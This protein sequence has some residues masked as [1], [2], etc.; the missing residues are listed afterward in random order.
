MKIRQWL[1]YNEDASQFALQPGELRILNNLQ[2]R[3]PG[4][5]IARSGLRKL[6]G[7]YNNELIAA[8][9]RRATTVGSQSDFLWMVRTLVEKNLSVEEIDA[10]VYPFM[11]EWAVKRVQDDKERIIDTLPYDSANDFCVAEDRHGRLFIFYGH[12]IHPRLY[13]PDNIANSAIPLGLDP[14][15]SKP[16]VLPS[17]DGF[18]LE[19][20]NII[21]GGATY[22]SPPE[23]TVTGGDPDREAKVKSIVE[24]GAV[25]GV[26]IIDGGSGYKTPPEI[27]VGASSMGVGF[28][29]RGI[30]TGAA[31]QATGFATGDVGTVVPVELADDET[32]GTRSGTKNQKILY[33]DQSGSIAEAEA[34]YNESTRRF[35]AEI[36]A[37]QTVGSNGGGATALCQFSPL[38]LGFGLNTLSESSSI[39]TIDNNFQK[40]NRVERGRGNATTSTGFRDFLYGDYWQGA[41]Y[42]VPRSSENATYGGL[43]ASGDRFVLG[44]SGNLNGRQA[45]VYWPD[46][47]KISVWFNTGVASGNLSQWVREDVPVTVETSVENETTIKYIDVPLKPRAGAKKVDT[48]AG[49]SASTNYTEQ[50]SL[51][52]ARPP[53]VRIFLNECPDSW[54]VGDSECLPTAVKESRGQR[55][56]W[57]SNSSGV[58]RPLVDISRNEDGELDATSVTITDPG[59]GWSQNTT[60]AIRLYQA[61]AYSQHVDYNTAVSEQFVKSAHAATGNYVE[62]Q[63]KA[64]A[65]DNATPHGPPHTLLEPVAIANPGDGYADASE[66]RIEL[67]KRTLIA[68]GSVSDPDST[69]IQNTDPEVGLVLSNGLTDASSYG[70]TIV[71]TDVQVTTGP[72]MGFFL[73]TSAAYVAHQS[74]LK[75]GDEFSIEMFINL[76]AVQTVNTAIISTGATGGEGAGT[77]QLSF[78]EGNR[79][80]FQVGDNDNVLTSSQNLETLRWWHVAVTRDRLK[81][82]TLWINGVQEDTTVF[83]GDLGPYG[84]GLSIGKNRKN[85]VNVFTGYLDEIRLCTGI[86]AYEGVQYFEPPS[87]FSTTEADFTPAGTVSWTGRQLDVLLGSSPG[88]IGTINILSQGYGY[89]VAP[90]ILVRGGKGGYGLSVLPV[91]EN[92]AITEVKIIDPGLN[93]ESDPELYTDSSPARLVAKMRPALRGI[94]R[95]AYRFTDRT[96]QVFKET[97]ARLGDSETTLILDDTTD[98]EADMIL[99]SD[100]LPEEARITS[101]K[102]NEV[103]INQK[104]TEMG[105]REPQWLAHEGDSEVSIDQV[106][107][108]ILS[109]GESLRPGQFKYSPEDLYRIELTESGNLLL[110]KR[111]RNP[112]N[113]IIEPFYEYLTLVYSSATADPF[114]IDAVLEMK[115]DG[116]LVIT[117]TIEDTIYETTST[118]VLFSTVPNGSEETLE[119]A[120]N[121]TLATYNVAPT[122]PVRVRDLSRPVAYSDLSPIVD[123][124]CGPSEDRTHSSEIIW[125]LTGINPPSRADKVE[126]WRTSGDQSLV[127]YRT[128]AYGIPTPNGV[129]IVGSDTLT[130]EELFDPDRP[131]YAAMPVVLPNGAVNAYRFGKPRDDMAVAVAFQDRLWYGVSTSSKDINTLFYSEFDEFESIPDINELPI[132]NNQK[133]TDSLTALAPFGSMLLAMQH[134]HTYALTYN[135]DPGLDASIQMLSHR[136]CLHQRCWDIH[137]NVL[138]AVDESGI[139]SMARNGEVADISL[140]LR[141]LFVSELLDFSKRD[142][143]FLQVDPRTHILRF[144]TVIVSNPTE[145][146]SFAACYDIQAK[147]W[148]TETYPNGLT[149]SVASR[150]SDT[151]RNTIVFGAVDGNTYEL[152]GHEDHNNHA[153]TDTFV[154]DGGSGYREAPKITVPNVTGATV[155][156]VVSEGRLVDVIINGPGWGADQGVTLVTEQDGLP[157]ADHAN[158]NVQGVEYAPIPLDIAPPDPGGRQAHAYANFSVTPV[159]RRFA[160]I[161]KG[162]SFVRVESLRIATF[163]PELET[164][165]TAENELNLLTEDG[166]VLRTQ[167]PF[168]EAG[169]EAVGD[170]I[171]LNSFV[172]HVD[173][174]NI[175][176]VHP[177]GS[178]V[179]IL[180]GPPRTNVAGTSE[181]WLEGGG[182]R[183]LVRFYKPSHSHIPFRMQTG[184]MQRLTED[185]DRRAAGEVDRSVTLLYTPTDGS[186]EVELLE[187]FNGREEPVPN[188]M[189]R[190]RG[191]P[192][193]F[194]HR[195][196]S[197]S[198][199]LDIDRNA[200]ALGFATGVA[201]AKFASRANAELTGSDQYV[202]YELHGRPYRSDPRQRLNFWNFD[203]TVKA[204]LPFV[205]HSVTV[206]GVVEDG[207]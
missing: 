18:F 103:E 59:G 139:Y 93:Y 169:M 117:G 205:M 187:R 151:R 133:S 61:N 53:T 87:D 111:T 76:T 80:R 105:K 48:V 22:N 79:L 147:T 115:D 84:G 89:S 175:Y 109:R 56:A 159:V 46:Y 107:A 10:G 125:N 120:K 199:V 194:V 64:D 36:P 140:P 63:F 57:F 91:V 138:Y 190:E 189:R 182:T 149:S 153:L 191:G 11:F 196:D 108:V 106:S 5:L 174:N 172:S 122:Y 101:V 186:K 77:W 143:F 137:E 128:E 146:P 104:I 2:P 95:C 113:Y 202:Q 166:R 25:V 126:L 44:F 66:I 152:D 118:R 83:T 192:G 206:E 71:F 163:E 98:I 102:G 6:Y 62:F 179:S 124:N 74:N 54:L 13:R 181:N 131:H 68:P 154:D 142:T 121:G 164:H 145:T 4:M 21:G 100:A 52:E 12:G 207:G 165:L 86:N 58:S 129:E 28:R 35:T 17:G 32:F 14:P 135:S 40:Y 39:T 203:P 3:R 156:G 184:F 141:D 134:N 96:D 78:F 185:V 201:E 157:I 26:D 180:S 24:A 51:P 88:K 38:P 8:M 155:Q 110:W 161:S 136:G 15:L 49:R 42:N 90:R 82:M 29:A 127:F 60:F 123:V 119:L 50:E 132:Q 55:L 7:R 130:D 34:T 99:E 75:L 158:R 178:P 37:R 167:P 69:R 92:G 43:Q 171:P 20:V 188:L 193:S 19:G 9:Y 150:P 85:D 204:P 70:N 173:R 195:Q 1:G 33:Y 27:K 16:S 81:N 162:E 23:L 116:Q 94:Y 197:A 72:S 30:S 200:S 160:T 168:V 47:S 97:V 65:P 73:P 45:D 148:W 114:C 112:G 183:I 41:E 177:D 31:Y 176:L 198:T 170:S 144:F 67:A